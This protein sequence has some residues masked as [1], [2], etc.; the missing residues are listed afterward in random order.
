MS[1]P[2]P[3]AFVI[4]RAALA[5]TLTLGLAVACIAATPA[6]ETP[7]P[8][9]AVEPSATA[10]PEPPPTATPIPSDTPTA[11]ATPTA[12]DTPAPTATPT[13]TP[14][15][16]PTP[17]PSPTP[18]LAEIAALPNTI[19]VCGEGCEH[20]SIQAALDD[21]ATQPGAIIYVTD[22]VHTE[23]GIVVGKDV[24]IRGR[25]A[26]QTVVQADERAGQAGDRVFFIPAGVSASIEDMTI[27]HGYPRADIRS[28]GA[29]ENQG[30]LTVSRCV[31]RDNQANCGG[32]IYNEGGT[33]AVVDSTIR[34]NQA[35]GEAPIGYECGAGG[36][37]KLTEGERW[38]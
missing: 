30:T 4:L 3:R 6:T 13:H 31:I 27:R 2:S 17:I 32:G 34:D 8:V 1:Q 15:P 33:L 23:A 36:A 14:V 25:A 28:G 5:L 22:A 19:T 18:S 9:A 38:R 12:T 29:I 20:T 21:P 35:D 7:S 24:T 11:T 26:N 37:I 16:S 10:I